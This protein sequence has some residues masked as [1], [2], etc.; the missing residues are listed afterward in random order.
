MTSVAD[1]LFIIFTAACEEHRT[2]R[3]TSGQISDGLSFFLGA[4]IYKV[5]GITS[6]ALCQLK[7]NNWSSRGVVRAHL[8]QR[9]VMI[10]QMI[11]SYLAGLMTTPDQ[12]WSLIDQGAACV[13]ATSEEN[14]THVVPEFIPLNL[15]GDQFEGV[16]WSYRLRKGIE[17]EIL[18]KLM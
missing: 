16:G 9:S 3:M 11:D 7:A 4:R 10:R 18:K 17:V 6:A 8:T 15:E 2:G 1:N 14:K 5:V 13:L 12:F